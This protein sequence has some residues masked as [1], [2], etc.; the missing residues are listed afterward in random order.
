MNTIYKL[1]EQK[2][3]VN[4]DLISNID[5]EIIKFHDA[6]I[7]SANELDI[8]R[9]KASKNKVLKD[10]EIFTS[11]KLIVNDPL[12]IKEVEDLISKTNMNSVKAYKTV[13]DKFI[14]K[15]NS[16]DNEYM[17]ERS[18]DIIDVY[19]RVAGIILNKN[20]KN[21]LVMTK[22]VILV[23]ENITPSMVLSINQKLVK[24]IILRDGGKTSHSSLM[25]KNLGIPLIIG[26]KE[27][28]DS[29]LDGDFIIM[30]GESGIIISS[31]TSDEIF[32]YIN[33]QNKLKK[34]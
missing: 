3:E 28:Y 21:N 11:H 6:L 16:M 25:I 26:V 4:N 24:G 14:A 1:I 12:I 5:K 31:P 20:T 8:L 18:I 32:D 9:E 27:N 30:D 23:T 10:L 29:L 15:F 13:I 22:D 17:K 2:I 7:Q 19:K 34:N 33:K